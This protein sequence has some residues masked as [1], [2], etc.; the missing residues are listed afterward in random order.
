MIRNHQ[1][2]VFG[3]DHYNPLTVIRTLGVKGIY[4]VFIGIKIKAGW[5]PKA[6]MFAK[7]TM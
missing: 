2:I 7:I 3:A 4:P 6:N 1:F 5:L